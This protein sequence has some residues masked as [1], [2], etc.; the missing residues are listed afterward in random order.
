GI[1]HVVIAGTRAE[2]DWTLGSGYSHRGAICLLYR[3]DEESR[4]GSS[5][6]SRREGIVKAALTLAREGQLGRHQPVTANGC[7][8]KERKLVIVIEIASDPDCGV[9]EILERIRGAERET[10]RLSVERPPRDAAKQRAKGGN[11][12]GVAIGRCVRCVAILILDV[13][14]REL[15]GERRAL[16]K[17]PLEVES[18]QHVAI[19][20]Y[21]VLVGQ[22]QQGDGI[23][24]PGIE[25]TVHSREDC[26][27]PQCDV[28]P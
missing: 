1:G 2:A 7:G 3:A 5:R 14:N 20:S 25:R 12:K 21:A 8:C 24:E 6:V 17:P 4:G 27:L 13:V 26:R 19:V 28:E 22:E 11:G 9:G 16:E 10:R 18:D 15:E 23:A